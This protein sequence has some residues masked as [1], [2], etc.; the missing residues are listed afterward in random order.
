MVKQL[1]PLA[2]MAKERRATP[3]RF[4]SGWALA[5]GV[6]LLYFLAVP[7]TAHAIVPSLAVGPLAALGGLLGGLLVFALSGLVGA[8]GFKTLSRKL[9]GPRVQAWVT[10]IITTLF[11]GA[12]G[13]AV[14]HWMGWR[15]VAYGVAGFA[16]FWA[17]RQW[18]YVL[19]RRPIAFCSAIVAV[20]GGFVAA[21]V[22]PLR[23]GADH[24]LQ[25]PS[26]AIPNPQSESANSQS[27]IRNPQ[28]AIGSWPMFRGGLARTGVLDAMPSP[29]A[30][31][32]AIWAAK[33]PT[34][35]VG[36]LSASP[37][38]VE[39]RV[40]IAGSFAS[41]FFRG[42]NIYCLDAATGEIRWRF[43]TQQQVFASPAVVNG[44]VYCGE[45]LHSDGNSSLYCLDATSGSLVWSFP[46]KSH[47][48][49]SPAVAD[50]K[51]FFGAG[52]DGLYCVDTSTSKEVW[53]YPNV[54]VDVPPAVDE[55]RVYFGT[56]YGESA[57][58][59]LDRRSGEKV[60]SVKCDYGAWGTPSVVGNELFYAIGNGNFVESAPEAQRFGRVI[61]CETASGNERWHADMPDAVL[62]SIAVTGDKVYFGCR[63]GHVYCLDRQTG[64]PVWKYK[65]GGP[66]V[67][68]PVA[69]GEQVLIGSDDGR[70]YALRAATGELAWEYDT[71]K[72]TGRETRIW[73]S[74]ALW[75]GR[76]F[77][78]SSASYVFC[79]GHVEPKPTS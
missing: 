53:H 57:M 10:G 44:R 12:L 70:L 1:H 66:V 34:V 58:Y 75:G 61:C 50:G 41:V 59:C 8:L 60:W 67:S 63:D 74:P 62:S 19:R 55:Q 3:K 39:G 71:A 31:V 26:A 35:S 28:S 54:H 77:F 13:L 7:S 38:V 73:S 17:F 64:G 51:V 16:I 78:G 9:R 45:G 21:T 23:R 40:Y 18:G 25:S 42:A 4:R 43:K 14:Y 6:G 29:A 27:A 2:D 15:G 48:E 46:T 47:V 76:L 69:D 37:A 56:G 11:L 22:I 33:D 24:S 72:V 30:P 49:S 52:D 32:D 65:T 36:D 5:S 68:S 79:I 20:I